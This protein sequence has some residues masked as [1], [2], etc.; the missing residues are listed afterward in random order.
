MWN[1]DTWEC[2]YVLEGHGYRQEDEEASVHHEVKLARKRPDLR[3]E[4][5]PSDYDLHRPPF[6]LSQ[7]TRPENDSSVAALM[8]R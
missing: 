2:D 1:T 7:W 4:W 8:K 6:F 3:H 5:L